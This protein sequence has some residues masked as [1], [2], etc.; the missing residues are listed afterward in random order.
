MALG[1]KFSPRPQEPLEKEIAEFDKARSK[2]NE[3]R[4]WFIAEFGGVTCR[5]TQLRLFGRFFNLMD[6]GER[7]AFRDIQKVQG[8]RCSQATVKGALKVA[9]ILSREDTD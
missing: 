7:R 8:R 6:E 1:A 5:D 4:D 2:I 3:F 9:E